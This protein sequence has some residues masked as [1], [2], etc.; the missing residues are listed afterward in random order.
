MIDAAILS[1]NHAEVEVMIAK[2]RRGAKDLK[3]LLQ[4]TTHAI[5]VIVILTNITNILGPILVGRKT[6]ALFGSQ[7]LG[8]VTA[9]LT[10]AT[11]ILSEIIPKSIGSHYAPL[12]GRMAAPIIL[13]CIYVLYPLLFVF[14]SLTS[15]FKSGERQGTGLGLAIVKHIINRHQGGLV[16]ESAPGMGAAFTAWFPQPVERR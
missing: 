12:V 2:K 7:S 11:I 3:K 15:V 8:I 5:I 14:D 1:V 9:L 13:G 16:V 10:F 4:H 6:E